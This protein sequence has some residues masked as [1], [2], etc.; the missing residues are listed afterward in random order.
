[1]F[2]E[3]WYFTDCQEIKIAS[4]AKL[5]IPVTFTGSFPGQTF[6]QSKYN[7]S[8]NISKFKVLLHLFAMC[9]YL[10]VLPMAHANS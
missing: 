4:V 3:G 5:S 2:P 6:Q 1:M 8:T 10:S 7:T 9:C